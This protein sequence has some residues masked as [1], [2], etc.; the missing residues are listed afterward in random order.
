MGAL[1]T[2]ND[3]DDGDVLRF[4]DGAV[5]VTA[6]K[7]NH[8][9]GVLA[10]RIEHR[11]RSVVYATD[12]EH[13]AEPDPRLVD[14]ARGTDVLI[15]DAQYTPE[16]YSGQADGRPRVGWG[17]STMVEGA[18]VANAAGAKR[19]ILFHHDPEQDDAAVR[20]KEA[21]AREHFAV[22]DAAREGMVIDL[23]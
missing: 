10:F 18:R 4:A 22:S 6:R 8:P 2:F 15:Y 20:R 11:G 16:E 17:H 23:I 21:L 7:L 19:L 5:T 3:I 14:L 9:Q 12:T 13:Y 1:L